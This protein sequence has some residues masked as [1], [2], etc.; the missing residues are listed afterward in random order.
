MR[1]SLVAACAFVLGTSLVVIG[2]PTPI[3]FGS[4]TNLPGKAGYIVTAVADATGDGVADV[5]LAG[6]YSTDLRVHPGNGDGTFGEAQSFPMSFEYVQRIVPARLN[7]DSADD[8][9]L[10]VAGTPVILV[11][12]SNG[13]GGFT[14][15]VSQAA[16]AQTNERETAVPV[17]WDG[18]GD[19]DIFSVS[20]FKARLRV[21]DGAGQFG[22]A[23]NITSSF[24]GYSFS[25]H[26]TLEAV[27]SDLDGDGDRDVYVSAGQV[28]WRAANGTFS[29]GPTILGG[30][31]RYVV[32]ADLDGDGFN[33]LAG[34]VQSGS[35]TPY[36]TGVKVLRHTSATEFGA[37]E[38]Y[39]LS[40]KQVPW[41]MV[42]TDL[43]GDSRS[44]LVTSTAVLVNAG[45]GTFGPPLSVP[46]PGAS[47][48]WGVATGDL[49]GDARP[50]I[51]TT[52][53]GN[54]S[55][56]T[57]ASVVE[58]VESSAAPSIS[59]LSPAPLYVGATREV[60]VSGQGFQDDCDV[61]F[62]DGVTV[63]SATLESAGSLRALVTVDDTATA[64]PREVTVRNPDGGVATVAYTLST[65]GVATI[66]SLTPEREH[67]G[68]SYDVVV[69]GTGFLDG[70]S[71]S[72][73]DGVS[74]D[75]V[76][77]LADDQ[78]RMTVTIDPAASVGPRDLV[79]D[80]GSG[81]ETTVT[82]AF[83]VLPPRSVDLTVTRGRLR[84]ITKA[85]RTSLTAVGTLDF[86]DESPDHAFDAAT[87]TLQLRIGDPSAPI[88]LDV[89]ADIGWRIRNGRAEWKSA[90]NAMGPRVHV[91]LDFTRHTF[92]VDVKRATFATPPADDVLVELTLGT[93]TG[94]S[95]RQWTARRGELVLR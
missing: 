26:S 59:A 50:D 8:F 69:A 37:V 87:E 86:N 24:P 84:G 45:D 17:D 19:L 21:N 48:F 16:D 73:G 4:I 57:S 47:G 64:G 14:E 36:G 53:V 65:G 62:G 33:D 90:R 83:A 12:L 58:V 31:G 34:L 95:V 9:V 89:P 77:V 67:A 76:V 35:P 25:A 93:E 92:R 63:D 68:A 32:S 1:R 13:T 11:F 2:A 56:T 72:L 81:L 49:T 88:V 75:Q 91:V 29:A 60:V 71:A 7:A 51:V 6:Y 28:Y 78:V 18:D 44:E 27:V 15:T 42:A 3:G 85:G 10:S 54:V 41:G 52:W 70:A 46:A 20:S 74:V 61:H 39:E 23:Q 80:N 22:A 38:P 66:D 79:L 82:G 40:S 5:V 30:V 43:D 55:F 94:T